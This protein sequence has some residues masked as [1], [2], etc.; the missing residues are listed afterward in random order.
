MEAVRAAAMEISMDEL[1]AEQ[2]EIESSFRN[3]RF[4][5]K[6]RLTS[7]SCFKACGGEVK[8]PFWTDQDALVGKSHHCFGD[9]MNVNLEQGPFLKD[10]G[11]IPEGS[12]PK[13][14]IWAHGI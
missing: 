7:L 14:F 4:A 2:Q 6:V 1:Q 13:K 11:E 12:I 5:Q 10:L 9:C 8:F 3:L